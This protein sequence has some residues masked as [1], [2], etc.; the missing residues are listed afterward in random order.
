METQIRLFTKSL[1]L[2]LIAGTIISCSDN[3]DMEENTLSYEESIEAIDLFMNKTSPDGFLES[4]DE[5][6]RKEQYEKMEGREVCFVINSKKELASVYSGNVEIPNIDFSKIS[7]ILCHIM[8][9]NGRTYEY[10]SYSLDN[11]KDETLVTLNFKYYVDPEMIYLAN[12]V[13]FYFYKVVPKLKAGKTTRV[14]ANL[15]PLTLE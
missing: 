5:R 10:E 8:I 6:N 13:D 11:S 14:E 15:S 2:C 1:L 7:L 9:P 12:F 4:V 3:D